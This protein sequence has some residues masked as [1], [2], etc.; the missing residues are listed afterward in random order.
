V[1]PAGI[2]IAPAAEGPKVFEQS[3]LLT[4]CQVPSM[5]VTAAAAGSSAKKEVPKAKASAATDALNRL[6]NEPPR[7]AT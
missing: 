2:V 5:Q 7:I 6:R 1:T 4:I 3:V